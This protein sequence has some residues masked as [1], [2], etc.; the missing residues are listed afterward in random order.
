MDNVT[1][2]R[3][4]PQKFS[5]RTGIYQPD[6]MT[7]LPQ[8]IGGAYAAALGTG[9]VSLGS[10][11]VGSNE[12]WFAY[13]YALSTSITGRYAIVVDSITVNILRVA[14]D[15]ASS[16]LSNDPFT[17]PLFGIVAAANSTIDLRA[18]DIAAT[19]DVASA[20]LYLARTPIASRLDGAAQ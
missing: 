9:E 2:L 12:L 15:T 14:S 8:R 18:V 7:D 13:H 11:V 16:T 4:R 1:I 5:V 6:F 19:T 17:T 10:A 3:N 20:F